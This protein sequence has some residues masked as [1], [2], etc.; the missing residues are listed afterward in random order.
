MGE[1]DDLQM[2]PQRHPEG[3]SIIGNQ[4]NAHRAKWF[5]CRYSADPPTSTGSGTVALK[6]SMTLRRVVGELA[7]SF[8]KPGERAL[9]RRSQLPPLLLSASAP[10]GGCLILRIHRMISL[11]FGRMLDGRDLLL[12]HH[13]RTQEGQRTS[14]RSGRTPESS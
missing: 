4:T 1:G 13:G 7:P 6:I 9:P 12:F 14:L 5:Q 10:L 3:T 2:E 11:F 8:S